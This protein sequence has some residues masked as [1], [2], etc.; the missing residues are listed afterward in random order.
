VCCAASM[1]CVAPEMPAVTDTLLLASVAFIARTAVRAGSQRGML[2]LS[3]KEVRCAG[4][5]R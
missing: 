4:G 2:A 3:Q 1:M 5:E